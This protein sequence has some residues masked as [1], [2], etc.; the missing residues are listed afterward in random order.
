[1]TAASM[2]APE[3]QAPAILHIDLAEAAEAARAETTQP[4]PY[5]HPEDATEL[6]LLEQA[7]K[8][9]AGD[10]TQDPRRE[11]IAVALREVERQR[12][13]RDEAEAREQ[14]LLAASR[15]LEESNR[16]L[17]GQR[18]DA[19]ALVFELT[20]F[21]ATTLGCEPSAREVLARIRAK[22]SGF[23]PPAPGRVSG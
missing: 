4:R 3:P 6:L 10:R 23:L 8:C 2:T 19:L 11:L 7:T 16:T 5:P 20:A 17:R 18:S 9:A 21:A 15:T 22:G 12:Y 14:Q 13:W 1:M